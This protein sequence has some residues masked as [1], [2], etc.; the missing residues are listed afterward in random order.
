MK[1]LIA[2]TPTH[3]PIDP[4][5]TRDIVVTM[6]TN[7]NSLR[8]DTLYDGSH[9]RAHSPEPATT[10]PNAAMPRRGSPRRLPDGVTDRTIDHACPRE[11]RTA[12][13]VAAPATAPARGV[14]SRRGRGQQRH[15]A[16]CSPR[17]SRQIGR[18]ACRERV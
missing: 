6:P 14:R 13:T 1:R 16:W 2:G 17:W 10:Q 11:S 5:C 15:G 9:T 12:I 4:A 7:H 18:A 8:L 3:A